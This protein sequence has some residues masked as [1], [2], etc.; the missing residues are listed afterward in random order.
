[1][2]PDTSE[3]GAV[4]IAEAIRREVEYGEPSAPLRTIPPFTVSIGCATG[5]RSH[6]SSLE[7][8]TNAADLAL[9][10]AKRNGRNGVVCA[11]DTV[12]STQPPS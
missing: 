4:Q 12:T 8:L 1:M 6:P 11:D 9:Y 2:L 5:R 10:A 3:M 7:E